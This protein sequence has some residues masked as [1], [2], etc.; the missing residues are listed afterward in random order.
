MSQLFAS[1]PLP[2][3][4]RFND[5]VGLFIHYDEAEA[6]EL[7]DCL[8]EDKVEFSFD[9]PEAAHLVRP[10]KAV[11]VFGKA[12]PRVVA[13]WLE[14]CGEEV[15]IDP[16]VLMPED[17]YHAPVKQLLSLGEPRR[18]EKRDYAAL[19]LSL[20]DVSALIRMATDDQLHEGPQ[21]SLVVWAPVHAWRALAQ[22]RAEE[23]IV[24]LVQLFCRADD[25]MDDWVNDDLPRALGRFGAVTLMP[26]TDYLGDVTHGDWSRTAAADAIGHV[27]KEQPE[28]RADC[29]ARLSAQLEH[30]AEQSERFNGFLIATL[31]DLRAVEAMPV[32]KRAFAAGRVDESVLGDVEDV[33]I[34]LGLKAKR[35]HPPKPNALTIMGDQFR[36]QWS[37]GRLPLPDADGNFPES[38][39]ESLPFAQP[40]IAPPKVGRNDPCPCGS[41]KK[42]KKCCGG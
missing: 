37:A 24:P 33:Q 6:E 4:L 22:L 38:E 42:Y 30:F 1:D 36:A 3:A 31:L 9:P 17:L 15:V 32:I 21:D 26:L 40:Y 14:G 10:G 8:L 19:G 29:I 39:T 35:E 5:A 13:E 34:E 25:G 23:A 12:H 27:G 7:R 28:T 2:V 11:F 16:A 41:G 20:N 18:D